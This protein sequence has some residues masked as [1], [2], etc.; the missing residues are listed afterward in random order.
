VGSLPPLD[1]D[2]GDE[3]TLMRFELAPE[4][5]SSPPLIDAFPVRVGRIV[6]YPVLVS[7]SPITLSR[8]ASS[9][10]EEAAALM[11]SAQG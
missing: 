2:I 10:T 11:E 4:E 6:G 9:A 7:P 8:L 1:Q 3:A 5:G